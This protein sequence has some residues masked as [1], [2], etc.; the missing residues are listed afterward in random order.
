MVTNGSQI[1]KNTHVGFV[2]DIDDDLISTKGDD[3]YYKNTFNGITLVDSFPDITSTLDIK[4]GD[5]VY[6]VWVEFTDGDSQSMTYNGRVEELAV[7][8][9]INSAQ[10]FRDI[11]KQSPDIQEFVLDKLTTT[12]NYANAQRYLDDNNLSEVTILDEFITINTM[13]G[14][15]FKFTWFPWVGYYEKLEAVNINRT[16]C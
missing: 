9:D 6:V 3:E 8:T 15:E 5:E 2:V 16:K 7:F 4:K 10:Q 14:Q 11:I 12:E 13:D 1:K